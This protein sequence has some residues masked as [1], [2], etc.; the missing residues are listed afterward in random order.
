MTAGI[1]GAG[2]GGLYYLISAL[3]MPFKEV[4]RARKGQSTPASR[5][6]VLRQALIALGIFTSLWGVAWLLSTVIAPLAQFAQAMD[7][8]G[9]HASPQ[10]LTRILSYW[11]FALS[12]ATLIGI[13]VV[14]QLLR[15]LVRP[16]TVRLRPDAAAISGK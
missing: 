3:W 10:V 13:A 7:E 14:V 16:T 15:L 9:P 11:A 6:L 1:P 2:I 5:R 8:F 4:Q 12:A